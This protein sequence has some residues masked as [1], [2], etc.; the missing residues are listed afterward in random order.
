MRAGSIF[1]LLV[2]AVMLATPAPAP[3][4]DY[5]TAAEAS[6]LLDKAVAEV[7]ADAKAAIAKFNDPKGAFRDRDLYVFCAE[8][9]S[10]NTIAHP[11]IVGTD[12]RTLKDKTGKPFGAE[13]L[14][15]AREGAFTE[16]SYMW[17]RPD[18]TEP[19][20]KVSRI[21]RIGDLMCGVG[22]YK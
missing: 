17:P 9:G 12:L 15:E 10:G 18:S 5:G 19:V 1:G 6:A 14:T 2:A 13:M 16:I 4:A 22:Y 11:S 8:T 3:A 20:E 21:T 7:K